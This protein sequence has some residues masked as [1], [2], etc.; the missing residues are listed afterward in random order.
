MEKIFKI[1]FVN[2]V[3][4]KKTFKKNKNSKNRLFHAFLIW[5]KRT[6]SSDLRYPDARLNENGCLQACG[7]DAPRTLVPFKPKIPRLT[8]SSDIVGKSAALTCE[9]VRSSSDDS[10][11]REQELFRCRFRRIRNHLMHAHSRWYLCPSVPCVSYTTSVA[12]RQE[13]QRERERE[14]EERWETGDETRVLSKV[15]DRERQRD[16]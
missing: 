13:R 8:S 1:F 2:I 6:N 3:L 11:N 14:R 15:V 4:E 7:G 12:D 10:R 16:L 5:K 9:G